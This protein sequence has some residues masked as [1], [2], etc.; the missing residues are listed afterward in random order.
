MPRCCRA[1]AARRR[2]SARSRRAT[3]SPASPSCRW[4]P[5][6]TPARC[7]VAETLEIGADESAGA[8]QARLAALGGELIVQALGA[9][10]KATLVGRAAAR[11]RRH[12]RRQDHARPR[13]RSTGARRRPRS[14][15]ACAPSIRR[16]ARGACWPA[17]RSPAGAASSA[18]AAGAPGEVVAVD[19]GAL[20]VAC[21]EGRLALTELQ[22]A[23]GR[24]MAAEALLRGWTPPVGAVFEPAP[25]PRRDH[26][27]RLN[28]A[29]PPPSS[30]AT[31]STRQT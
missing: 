18:R 8:L 25:D 22:R 20:T 4:T 6:S 16:R 29:A 28:F 23:G 21:G 11:G 5:A 26:E 9:L 7:C 15:A 10:A 3:T 30:P 19:G 13:R 1:G 31:P 27:G 17:R 24:R 14:S 12:L 2:S